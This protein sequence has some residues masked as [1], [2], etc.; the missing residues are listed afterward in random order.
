M[1][2]LTNFW[3]LLSLILYTM[4]SGL[5]LS[6]LIIYVCI[7]KSDK[8]TKL[9]RIVIGSLLFSFLYIIGSFYVN[10]LSQ[11]IGY[12]SDINNCL[13]N[14]IGMLYLYIFTNMNVN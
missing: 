13:I 14:T 3:D 11:L 9:H 7:F 4:E 5:I 10:I 2:N 6:L 1:S 8:K 12:Y